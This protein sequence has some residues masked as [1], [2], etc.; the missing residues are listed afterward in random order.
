MDT[1]PVELVRLVYDFCD[2]PSVRAFRLVAGRYADVGYEFLL[3]PHFTAVE[4]RDD[5][6]RLSAIASHPRLRGSIRA[7]T[8]SFYKP[9]DLPPRHHHNPLPQQQPHDRTALLQA[10]WARYHAL[11]STARALPPFH[12]RGPCLESSLSALPNLH[13]L[14]I[15]LAPPPPSPSTI[16][17]PPSSY[18]PP[19][20]K[21][22]RTQATKNV[23]TLISALQQTT[24]LTSL[25]I[26]HLPL[27]I[28]RLPA[29]RR[30][31]STCCARP[32]ASLTTL[33]LVLDVP[34]GMLP[35]ARFRAVNG[36][37]Q[38]LRYS[39]ELKALSLAFRA[40]HAPMEKFVLEFRGLFAGEEF[41]FPRL[42]DLKLE[43]VSCGEEDLRGFLVRHGGSLERLRLG[44]RG[45]AR[46]GEVSIGGV[47]LH[48]G[49]FR[50]L[51]AGL[52]GRMG[53]LRRF[54]MEGDV[55]AGE[56]MASSREV[57]LFR[58]VSDDDWTPVAGGKGACLGPEAKRWRRAEGM[59]CVEPVDCLGLERFLVEGGEYPRLGRRARH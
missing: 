56:Y 10:A 38:V 7:L 29:D 28:F 53:R 43:G 14:S 37:G 13:R 21:R 25:S 23:N 45:L 46:E 54:H 6:A 40:A 17:I 42:T 20:P 5:V 34:R 16:S 4:W 15:S 33:N 35:S 44:G 27:E 36:L 57:Y 51:F 50:G 3:D 18:S 19:C 2:G 9:D 49:S 31:W 12:T 59:E 8:F 26:D 1:L 32:F 30:H 52:R 24:S 47:H 41:V 48:E 58:A 11:E 39:K 55:E 22:S